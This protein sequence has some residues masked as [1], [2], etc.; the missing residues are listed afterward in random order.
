MN[1]NV[2]NEIGGTLYVTYDNGFGEKTDTLTALSTKLLVGSAVILEAVTAEL[3]TFL[4]WY[5]N[6]T[7]LTTENVYTFTTTDTHRNIVAKFKTD[8]TTTN[9]DDVNT[10]T[11]DVYK[12]FRDG[13]IYIYKNG[14]LHTITGQEL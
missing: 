14:S 11:S 6:D 4:G 2:E 5:E 8:S 10:S 3:S 13:Q 12:I 7:L 9:I 1:V